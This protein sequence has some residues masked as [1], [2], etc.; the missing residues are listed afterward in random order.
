MKF[1]TGVAIGVA[2]T[3][4]YNRKMPILKRKLLTDWLYSK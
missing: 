1:A 3:I 2:G 4:I